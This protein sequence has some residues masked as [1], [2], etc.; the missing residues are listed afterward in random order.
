MPARS[1]FTDEDR[2]LLRDSVAR[3]VA[4]LIAQPRTR[5]PAD[6]PGAAE[7][8]GASIPGT[9]PA[10][11]REIADLGLAGLLVPADEGGSG[12]GDDELA[13]VMEL[14]GQ[15]LVVE[16]FL[17]TAVL[18]VSLVDTLGDTEL[19]ARL[20]PAMAAGDL[21]CALAHFEPDD[22]FGRDP[23]GTQVRR[24]GDTLVLHGAKS[25][26]L[27]APVA[28]LLLVSAREGDGRS[29]FL[30]PR[31]AEGL[32]LQA[33]T[34]VDGRA[35]ADLTLD[36]VRVHGGMRLG[37]A[38]EAAAVLDQV[39][40]RATLAVGSDALG[41]MQSVLRQTT[42]YLR[43]RT[44]FGQ[45]LARFQVLQHRAVD[46]HIAIEESRAL[47][48]AARASLGQS[49][50][51]RQAA[52]AAAKYKLGVSARYVAEQSVQLHGAMGMT[53]E[54]A[55]SHHFKRLLLAES[56]F[57]DCDFQLARFR[58]AGGGVPG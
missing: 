27:D 53:D 17:G 20:L 9:D 11:W 32:V 25:C 51:E 47:L 31:G 2:A 34:T 48:A 50:P 15:G 33:W 30:L 1:S 14:L 45:P 7:G 13:L 29:L 6:A 57:G 44:Q 3:F 46:M 42:E 55:V 12:G 23:S 40:D 28:D 49:T 24:Q 56:L 4:R 36:G 41:S 5:A 43:T 19:R 54:L 10:L 39:L 16:P 35:A 26:V 18:G 21:R 52:V 38:G 22:G 8:S 37:A 58:A